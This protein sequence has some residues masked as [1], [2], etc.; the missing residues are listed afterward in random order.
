MPAETEGIDDEAAA[1]E[2]A[3]AALAIDIGQL[4]VAALILL[5]ALL[6][7]LQLKSACFGTY[8]SVQLSFVHAVTN[9]F[10]AW[11]MFAEHGVQQKQSS[12]GFARKQPQL[13][14][15]Y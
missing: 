6:L 7:Y 10:I 1:V 3:N 4:Q 15:S 5:I 11:I 14:S 8:T 12:G 9:S 13:G 2:T